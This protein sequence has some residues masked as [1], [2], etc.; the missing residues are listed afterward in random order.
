MKV[1]NVI[2]NVRNT[3]TGVTA[4]LSAAAF[5]L[6]AA[7][8]MTGSLTA[9][10][11][12]EDGA[13]GGTSGYLVISVNDGGIAGEDGAMTRTT[14]AALAAA[15]VTGDAIGIYAWDGED[16]IATNAK[17][18]LGA[19]GE[20]HADAPVAYKST[21]TYCAYYPFRSDHGYTPANSGAVDVRF[22]DFITDAGGKFW[23]ADQSTTAAHKGSDLCTSQGTHV[24]SYNRVTF[25]MAHK[26][27]LAVIDNVGAAVFTGD[28][29]PLPVGD[30]CHFIMKASTATSFTAGGTTFSLTAAAGQYA[31]R[32]MKSFDYLTF[33]AIED[34][35][36][37][38]SIPAA[39]NTSYITSVS[40]SLDDGA[41]WTTTANSASVVTITTPTVTAGNKVL[42]KGT[43]VKY[44]ISSSAY[45]RFTSTAAYE[46]SG[47]IMSLLYGDSFS[48]QVSLSGKTYCF[49]GL[50]LNSTGLTTPPVLPATTLAV[51]CYQ[52]MFYGC[53]ALTTTPTLP[54]KAAAQ[55]CYAGMFQ[56]CTGLT[57]TQPVSATTLANYCYQNMFY[58]CTA[59]TTTPTLPATTLATACYTQM[60]YN[61][62]SLNT[63]TAAFTTT[64]GTSYTNNWLYGVAAEGTFYKKTAATWN[65]VNVHGVP[66]GWTIVRY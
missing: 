57:S 10:T 13:G 36:F 15:F 52:N 28:N 48:G 3:L 32:D 18:V 14:D 35:T 64:P 38:L 22:A 17:Y 37:T 63:V 54:A 47:N 33:T 29:I 58:G 39:V 25:T 20:W 66:S 9:C 4:S 65:V 53:T 2:R 62:S 55:Y 50:F 24:G 8:M 7:V 11:Q 6:S 46:V 21:Y 19:D 45:A 26:R 30:E 5:M 16:V 1:M 56:G 42:W 31:I 12:D 43:A 34:G 61:C 49:Y 51:N 23:Y 44:G 41:N 60:F 27:A 40:Y 59:L